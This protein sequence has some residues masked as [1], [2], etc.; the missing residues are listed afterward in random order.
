[1]E[2]EE[3][4][5]KKNINYLEMNAEKYEYSDEFDK[6]IEYYKKALT[7]T[8]LL[9]KKYPSN[10]L[11]EDYKTKLGFYTDKIKELSEA[12]PEGEDDLFYEI[13]YDNYE[14]WIEEINKIEDNNELKKRLIDETKRNAKLVEKIKIL[15]KKSKF[16]E[17]E[18][19]I[20]ENKIKELQGI[21]NDNQ[22]LYSYYN[23]KREEKKPHRCILGFPF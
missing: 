23:N 22:D 12:E 7:E 18:N 20:Y 4:I 5:I 13:F 8:E 10:S 9:F 11:L 16:F 6:A 15:N 19:K 2:K 17:L 3:D 21:K 14:K 1:M